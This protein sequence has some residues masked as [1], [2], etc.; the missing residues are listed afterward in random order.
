ML[1]AEIQEMIRKIFFMISI[2]P[3]TLH[4]RLV[5][6]LLELSIKKER[7]L[8]T[9]SHLIFDASMIQLLTFS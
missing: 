3:Q 7:D 4:R 1:N 5:N 9:R 2:S 6:R 8:Q